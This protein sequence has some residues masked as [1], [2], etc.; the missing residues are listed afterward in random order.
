MHDDHDRSPSRIPDLALPP[1][2]GG[3][4]VPLRVRRHGTVI[5]LVARADASLRAYAAT[6]AEEI[7]RLRGWDGRV[8]LVSADAGEAAAIGGDVPFPVLVDAT[9][10]VAAAAG[11]APPAV[12]VADQWGMVHA[13][14]P[15]AHGFL[16]L[17]DVEG[18]LRYVSIR[19]AG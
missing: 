3:A 8:L 16:A 11:V 5:V 18:W 15:A 4:P 17:D 2:D 7:E 1:V 12:V 10:A 19:C 9:G 13:A 14:A 6:L